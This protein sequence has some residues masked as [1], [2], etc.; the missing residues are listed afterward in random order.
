MLHHTLDPDARVVAD[1]AERA[2]ALIA[3][4]TRYRLQRMKDLLSGDDSGLR[5]TWDEVC[6]QVQGEQSFYGEEYEDTIDS[7]ILSELRKLPEVELRA[8]WLQTVESPSSAP[9]ASPRLAFR[10]SF[11]RGGSPRS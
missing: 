7:V 3:K 8:L 10:V 5:N 4:R 1:L 2:A 9:P 6:A 11:Q